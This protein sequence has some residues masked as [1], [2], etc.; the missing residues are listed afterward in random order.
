MHVNFCWLK[1]FL[2]S[3]LLTIIIVAIITF[4]PSKTTS[5]QLNLYGVETPI[6]NK[7]AERIKKQGYEKI[8]Y[9]LNKMVQTLQKNNMPIELSYDIEKA[10]IKKYDFYAVYHKVTVD[11]KDY[12]F[13]NA[14]DCDDFI[15]NI[16]K[17]SNKEYEITFVRLMVYKETPKEE[18]NKIIASKKAAY[19]KALAEA[20]AKKKAEEAARKKAQA[21]AAQKKKNNKTKS[22]TKTLPSSSYQQY[23]YNLVINTY[24]WS[25]YD[26]QCLVKLWN[27]ESGWNPNA[28]N[29]KSGAHGIPQALPAKKMASEGSDYYTNG[30][31][32]IRWGLKYIKNRYGSPSAAWAHS[33]A[34]HW[35]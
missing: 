10:I 28:H 19:E 27:R 24:G 22:K 11:N 6:L 32:Q 23:A 7:E 33:Q 29:K 2:I 20:E 9:E 14:K 8:S 30:Y 16:K 15:K 5:S 25:E 1:V 4:K 18:I 31:T 12:I 35:Y 17:Y 3:L 34:H 13:K 26:F 21:E